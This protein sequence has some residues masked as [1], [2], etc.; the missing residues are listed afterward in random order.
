MLKAVKS[1]YGSALQYADRALKADRE[2]VLAAVKKDGSVLKHASKSLQADREVVLAAVKHW[3]GALEYAASALQHDKELLRIARH[4]LSGK[5]FILTGTLRSFSDAEVKAEIEAL[6]GSVAGDFSVN[7]AGVIVGVGRG[8]TANKAKKLGITTFDEAAFKRL[9]GRADGGQAVMFVKIV[10]SGY[11]GEVLL[12]AVSKKA[13]EF[14]TSSEAAQEHFFEYVSDPDS[15]VEEHPDFK[16]LKGAELDAWY[17]MT[18]LGHAG[19]QSF[20]NSAQFTIS[21]MDGLGNEANQI[22][23]IYDG[24]LLGFIREHEIGDNVTYDERQPD[25]KYY[26]HGY[27]AQ[28]GI[29]LSGTSEIP[30]TVFDPKKLHFSVLEI[31]HYKV[32]TEVSYADVDR[33]NLEDPGW[34]DGKSL[35]FELVAT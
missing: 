1:S 35:D 22:C 11:G 34:S 10:V 5:A 26:F 12:G 24:T 16:V 33:L 28:K 6:G 17:N 2:I 30:G 14:W 27:N 25:A 15:F 21:E 31:L 18:D 4:N 7:T 23:K 32:L 9:I 13:Y 20:D 8:T 29:F 19:T 3:R